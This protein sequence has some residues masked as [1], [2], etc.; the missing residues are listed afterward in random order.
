MLAIPHFLDFSP[1]VTALKRDDPKHPISHSGRCFVSRTF[2]P[3]TRRSVTIDLTQVTSAFWADAFS[4]I[5]FSGNPPA[6]VPLSAWLPDQ[7][8]Q[9]IAFENGLAKDQPP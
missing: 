3:Q 8:M 6:L 5:P 9:N 4:R 2:Y 7:V 1:R